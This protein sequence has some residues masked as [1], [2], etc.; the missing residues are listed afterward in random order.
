MPY[1]SLGIDL[2]F[3]WSPGLET[4]SPIAALLYNNTEW[5]EP[6]PCKQV[7]ATYRSMPSISQKNLT[8]FPIIANKPSCGVGSALF[9]NLKQEADLQTANLKPFS[10]ELQRSK[11][12]TLT[13]NSKPQQTI[14]TEPKALTAKPYFPHPKCQPQPRRYG[15]TKLKFSSSPLL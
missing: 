8:Q 2:I 11:P 12:E 7:R 10:P 3:G 4:F 13:L 9:L 5:T 6:K 14:N 15:Q 1:L